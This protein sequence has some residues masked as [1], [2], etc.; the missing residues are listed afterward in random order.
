M[1]RI[2]VCPAVLCVLAGCVPTSPTSRLHAVEVG[3][4][5]RQGLVAQESGA[6]VAAAN[7]VPMAA[8]RWPLSQ[9][10]QLDDELASAEKL[11]VRLVVG[12]LWQNETYTG[13]PSALPPGW[14]ALCWDSPQPGCGPNYAIAA[15]RAKALQAIRDLAA[16][17]D[18]DPRIA[19]FTAN[20]GDD[21]ERRFC[22]KPL[23]TGPGTCR[24]AYDEAG[25]DMGVWQQFVQDVASTAAAS[26]HETPVLFH[27]SGLGYAAWELGRD[28][29]AA[30]GYGLGLMSSGLYPGMCTGNSH[31][32]IC[33]PVDPLL[34]DWQV[35]QVYPT[36]PIAMEQSWRYTGNEAAL[37]WL[38][39]VTH[40]A[41]QIHAQRETL[42]NS[43]GTEWR[44]T[45]EYMLSHPEAA[46]WVARDIDPYHCASTYCGET[47][48]WSRNVDKATAGDLAYNVS[49][50][51]M[52][53]VAR[54]APV[55]LETAVT[56][57]AE[58]IVWWAD[59]EREAWTQPSGA[60]VEVDGTDYV[61]RVEARPL[62]ATGKPPVFDCAGEMRD[63]DWLTD[64][65]PGVRYLRSEASKAFRLVAVR[66]TCGPAAVVVRVYGLD[67][68]PAQNFVGLYWPEPEDP[69]STSG[70]VDRWYDAVGAMQ[71]TGDDG[72]TGF[73]LGANSYIGPDGGP[74]AAWVLSPSA[75]SDALDRFGMLGGTNH[76][77]P[78]SLDFRLEVDVEPTITATPTRAATA[79]WT[80]TWTPSPSPTAT[81]TPAPTAT[82]TSTPTGTATPEPGGGWRIRGSIGDVIVDIIVEER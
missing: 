43:I 45:A 21:G 71:R 48:D 40:G 38:W 47:G 53:W 22:K 16:E 3:A 30:V 8:K 9:L 79:T 23:V 61:H 77:G 76:Y 42:A 49:D 62:E 58:V 25:L 37:A 26:F 17:Y 54:R 14:D 64:K 60:V 73:G 56:G 44:E 12:I 11:G 69:I 82:A 27:Y 70:A 65:Y 41:W 59:G 10:H 5:L 57:P 81:W 24:T 34:N 39:A 75:G 19:A 50:F 33:N 51:Y 32:G 6:A 31:G 20:V 28:V 63:W 2:I 74:H 55:R 18:G 1:Q 15:T 7:G 29:E 80:P 35:S 68:A 67:G 78:L 4:E 72:H 13:A 46:L 66:E 36:V 52:G